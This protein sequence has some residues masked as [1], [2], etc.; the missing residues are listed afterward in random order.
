MTATA[1]A[2]VLC[3]HGLFAGRW[4]FDDLLPMLA[5][6]GHAASAI[7]LRCRTETAGRC[8]LAEYRD[9][10]AAA[11]R[12]M[13]RPVV[14]AH[15]MGGLVAQ[16]LAARQLVRAVVLVSSAPPRGIP[17]LSTPLLARI[18]RYLP[19]LLRSRP[20]LPSA[21]DFDALVLNCI[22]PEQRAAIRDRFVA[23]S[24]RVAREIA[25]GRFGVRPKHIRV[26]MLVMGANQDRFVPP[27]V[28]EK[29]AKRYHAPLYM[30]GGHGHF[31]FGE[32]GWERHARVMLDWID[33][34]PADVPAAGEPR[35]A[36]RD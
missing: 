27:R 36:A 1:P 8:S 4:V 28:A 14:I 26:P 13:D 35:P 25:I 22:P 29:L 32:P 16:L 34:L 19:A 6:R 12:A 18:G 20:L 23:D 30:A 7:D 9:T 11:A 24:G 31:L 15:S 21:D 10:A 33:G 5:E 17:A 2:P 3:L